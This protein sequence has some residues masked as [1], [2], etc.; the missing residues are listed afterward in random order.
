MMIVTLTGPQASGKTLTREILEAHKEEI[1][2][3]TGHQIAIREVLEDIPQGDVV[4]HHPAFRVMRFKASGKWMDTFVI[5]VLGARHM[6]TVS[7]FLRK[8]N[9]L[10][11]NGSMVVV[12][13]MSPVA[14]EFFYPIEVK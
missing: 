10:P 8:S 1:E 9:K 4:D 13:A 6:Q 14:E 3:K 5:T 7:D 2:K 12:D 11:K